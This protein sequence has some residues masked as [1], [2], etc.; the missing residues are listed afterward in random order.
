VCANLL[1]PGGSARSSGTVERGAETYSVTVRELHG[2]ER[3][4]IYHEH[5]RRYAGSPTTRQRT[6]GIRTIPVLE[7]KRPSGPSDAWLDGPQDAVESSETVCG[8]HPRR[9]GG[10]AQVVANEQCGRP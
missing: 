10:W 7:L 5:A 2:D 6:A 9:R 8:I 4:R 1:A 3:D